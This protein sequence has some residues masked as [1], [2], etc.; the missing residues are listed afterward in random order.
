MIQGENVEDGISIAP[1]PRQAP[2]QS[3]C[4]TLLRASK[5]RHRGRPPGPDLL[6]TDKHGGRRPLTADQPH[7]RTS[8]LLKSR[9]CWRQPTVRKW[10]ATGLGIPTQT[11]GNKRASRFVALATAASLTPTPAATRTSFCLLYLPWQ[12]S[13]KFI[14]PSPTCCTVQFFVDDPLL[15]RQARWLH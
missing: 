15:Q 14:R 1:T 4:F 12:I 8:R 9:R 2:G 3:S 11:V 5:Q 7:P 13:L 10:A 6:P